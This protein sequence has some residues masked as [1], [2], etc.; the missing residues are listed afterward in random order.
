MRRITDG[1]VKFVCELQS[2]LTVAYDLRDGEL[3][4]LLRCHPDPQTRSSDCGSS[5]ALSVNQEPSD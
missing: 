4:L 3:G 2:Q 5:I 1:K